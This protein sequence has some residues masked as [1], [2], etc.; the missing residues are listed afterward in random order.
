MASPARRKES[1]RLFQNPLLEK[2]THV[3]P[4]IPLLVF[5]PIITWLFLE[6]A[7]TSLGMGS[8]LAMAVV[9]LFFWT[10]FEYAM[11]RFVFHF[12]AKNAVSKRLVFL[13]HGIHHD[14]PEDATRLVMPPVVSLGLAWT[15][16]HL[17][18]LALGATLIWPFFGG[19]L[20][21]YLIYDYTHYAI[22]HFT[23]RTPAGR[24]LKQYHML[25]HFV[26]SEAKWGVSSPLWD[27]VFGTAD[28]NAGQTSHSPRS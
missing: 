7:K 8:I 10:F 1:I 27:F 12:A 5:A 24:F 25:H 3:H 16:F 9:G 28:Q 14:D 22:H 4:I 6:A 13:F 15:F 17:F 19:F 20:I 11:H 2:L 18:E 23:P 26:A 21:G